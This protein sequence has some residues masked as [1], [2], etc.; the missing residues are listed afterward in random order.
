MIGGGEKLILSSNNV[1]ADAEE[2]SIDLEL[3]MKW[4][5]ITLASLVDW[6]DCASEMVG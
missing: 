1:I 2:E 4:G 6:G 3:V 5:W